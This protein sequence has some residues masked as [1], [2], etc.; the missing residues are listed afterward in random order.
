MTKRL[1]VCLFIQVQRLLPVNE[2]RP[3]GRLGDKAVKVRVTEVTDSGHRALADNGTIIGALYLNHLKYTQF[4]CNK[5]FIRHVRFLDDFSA[6][7][8]VDYD[9]YTDSLYN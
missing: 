7:I 9:K 1:N 2:G 6:R 4:H 3:P 8:K 5:M